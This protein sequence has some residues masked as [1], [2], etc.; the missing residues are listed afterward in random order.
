MN[1]PFRSIPPVACVLLLGITAPC[2]AHAQPTSAPDKSSYTLFSPTPRELLRD[3]STD[4]PD[5]TESPHTVDAGHIQ[6]EMDVVRFT[7]DS[8]GGV[9]A[10]ELSIAPIN[11]KVGLLHNVDVQLLFD[12]HVRGR[13]DA[14]PGPA[15]RYSD[16]GDLAT[17]LK[18]NLWGNDDGRTALAIMPYVKWPLSANEVR[19]GETEGGIIVP[20]G[21]NIGGGWSMGL[22]TEVDFVSDGGGGHDTEWLNTITFSRDL[23]GALGG[24]VEFAAITSSA[25]DSEW[26][27]YLDIGFTYGFG[28]DSQLDFGCN[29]GVTRSAADFQ[30]FLGYTRRY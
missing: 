3:L 8:Q 26:Q 11:L 14:G 23:A 20:F 7:S 24:F 19:N 18:I 27:G 12:P 17:R 2:I 21:A 15:L 1:T 30:P 16:V 5:T 4:R 29:F 9:R 28:P 22:M 13:V 25:S 10:R 6:L